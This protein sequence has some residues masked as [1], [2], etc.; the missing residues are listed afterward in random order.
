MIESICSVLV[1]SC[2]VVVVVDGSGTLLNSI[3]F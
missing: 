2:T 3:I 1:I